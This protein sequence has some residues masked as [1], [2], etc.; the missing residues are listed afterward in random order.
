MLG[1]C[2][3]YTKTKVYQCDKTAT[4]PKKKNKFTNSFACKICISDGSPF[5]TV[6]WYRAFGQTFC[7]HLQD[8]KIASMKTSISV[9]FCT[10]LKLIR[11]Q[12]YKYPMYY[13]K[14]RH[15]IFIWSRQN[16]NFMWTGLTVRFL[17]ATK[18][19]W[20]TNFHRNT[21]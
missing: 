15:K 11:M 17:T 3:S 14:K 9:R 1:Y 7:F 10:L 19:C 21:K 5:R 20:I 16:V 13:L 6:C 12:S 4:V 2:R 18:P 8:G